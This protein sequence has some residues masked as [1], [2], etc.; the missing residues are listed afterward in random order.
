MSFSVSAS[1][2]VAMNM[3]NPRSATR[4]ASSIFLTSPASFTAR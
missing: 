4:I 3:R 1:R 2:S